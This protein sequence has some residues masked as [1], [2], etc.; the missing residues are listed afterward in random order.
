M[1]FC[2]FGD[3]FGVI[4]RLLML[5]ILTLPVQAEW[6]GHLKSLHLNMYFQNILY[7]F[8]IIKNMK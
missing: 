3:A 7:V 5:K 1:S 4:N 6:W 8:K 2:Y